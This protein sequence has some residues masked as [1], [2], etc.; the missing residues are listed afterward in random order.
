MRRIICDECSK[1]VRKQ[2]HLKK[3]KERHICEECYIKHL[4]EHREKTIEDAGIKEELKKLDKKIKSDWSEKNKERLREYS[5]KR[6]ASSKDYEVKRYK[7]NLPKIKPIKRTKSNCYLTLQEKQDLFKILIKK[8]LSYEETTERIKKL[9]NQLSEV[10][11]QLKLQ[12]KEKELEI[13]KQKFLEE[14]YYE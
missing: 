6:Y 2:R 3:L 13:S 9:V 7:Q 5:R 10:R 11:N 12:N 14:L 8:G 4:K 1:E